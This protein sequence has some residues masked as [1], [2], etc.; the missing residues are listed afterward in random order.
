M[1]RKGRIPV[2]IPKGVEVTIMKDEVSVK[3]PKGILKTHLPAGVILTKEADKV[4]VTVEGSSKK[5]RAFHGLFRTLLQNMIVGVTSGFEKRLE[6]Q[7]VGYRAGVQGQVIDLQIGTSH[8]VK[9]PIPHG[10]HVKVDKNTMITITG[11]DKQAVGQFAA[12][13]RAKRPPEPYQGKGI[14][15]DGEYVRRKAG[16]AAKTAK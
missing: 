16:K 5:L 1:S 2:D 10:M 7:G 12:Q 11:I 3:G 13:I 15:Y 4:I 8:P 6:M 14:R 9:L